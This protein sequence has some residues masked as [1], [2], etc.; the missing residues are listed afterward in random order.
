MALSPR[1]EQICNRVEQVAK[2]AVINNTYRLPVGESL[3]AF[4]ADLQ[5]LVDEVRN[6]QG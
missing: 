2:G 4:R 5:T 3:T 1:L 6:G